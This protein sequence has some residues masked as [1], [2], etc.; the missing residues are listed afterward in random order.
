MPEKVPM[1]PAADA[2]GP[3]RI[4]RLSAWVVCLVSMGSG[5][6]LLAITL[7]SLDY[8]R[9]NLAYWSIMCVLW[10]VLM[11]WAFMAGVR[12]ASIV[13]GD[14]AVSFG[15]GRSRR[16][17]LWREAQAWRD[18]VVLVVE[19]LDRKVRINPL[20]AEDRAAFT[21]FFEEQFPGLHSQPEGRRH[22]VRSKFSR[23]PP[24]T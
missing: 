16:T 7:T 5:L 24:T 6:V 9:R 21:R 12:Q 11:S 19:G 14:D 13:I 23:P 18:G 1:M 4:S 3:P 22:A 20:I 2:H 15:L 10:I 8:V 17:I